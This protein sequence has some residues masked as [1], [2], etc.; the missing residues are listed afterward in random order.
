MTKTTISKAKFNEVVLLAGQLWK[1]L[2]LTKCDAEKNGFSY[3]SQSNC[4]KAMKAFEKW[5]TRHD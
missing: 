2:R 4:V 5:N 3:G 1:A